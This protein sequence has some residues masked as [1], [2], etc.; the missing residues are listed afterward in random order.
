[1]IYSIKYLDPDQELALKP[2]RIHNTSFHYH[3]PEVIT[4][5]ESGYFAIGLPS[6]L[7]ALKGQRL[8]LLS[9][10]PEVHENFI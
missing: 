8:I 3:G 7:L 2:V 4:L 5:C 1:M 6:S 9:L 10:E